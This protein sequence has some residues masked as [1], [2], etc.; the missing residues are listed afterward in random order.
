MVLGID[1]IKKG[2]RMV[3][4]PVEVRRNIRIPTRDDP[5]ITLSADLFIAITIDPVPAVI[6]VLP[7]RKDADA[8]IGC[9]AHYRWLAS[10]GYGCLLV[11]F[12]GTGSSDG[13][14]RPPFDPTEVDDAVAA[15]EWAAAQLWCSGKVGMWGM[16]YGAIMTLRTGTVRPAPLKAILPIEGLLDPERDFVHPAGSAGCMGS[17][18]L[19]GTETFLNQMLPPLHDY[20]THDEQRR[21]RH[22][23]Q[24]SEPWL[25]DLRRH[26]PGH[27]IWQ[28]RIIDPSKI[29]VPAFCVAGWRDIFCDASLRAYELIST[30]KKLLVGPWMH[31]LPDGSLFEAI[32]FRTLVLRW[33]DQWLKGIDTGLM[34]ELPVTLFVQGS[35]P[36]W[37]QLASWPPVARGRLFTTSGDTTLNPAVAGLPRNPKVTSVIA[38]WK[39]DPTVGAQSGLWGIPANGFGLPLDQH[40]DDVRCITSTTTAI[41]TDVVVVGRP[42]IRLRWDNASSPGRLVVRLTD[43][44]EN[45][46]SALISLGVLSAP[47]LAN[48]H[49][50]VLNPT[51]YRIQPGHR[52]RVSVGNAD[53]PRLWPAETSE[54]ELQETLGLSEVE[55]ELLEMGDGDG[56]TVSIPAPECSINASDA[57]ALHFQPLWTIARDPIADGVQVVVGQKLIALSPNREHLLELDYRSAARVSRQ[58][59]SAANAQST[60]VATVRMQTGETITVRVHTFLTRAGAQLSAQI[61]IDNNAIFNREWDV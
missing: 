31:S 5:G 16:S 37:R 15:I 17:L 38:D 24:I 13:D 42:V 27:P 4:Y 8:G 52:L 7:Y 55:L 25:L 59:P 19:W 20:G 35:R 22:R 32:E 50:V 36:G 46:R 40:E 14:Q 51:C 48:M 45:G 28:S 53:F 47:E 3:S 44:D 61:A 26:G 9:D 54:N 60:A 6:T 18:S 12:R 30:P 21:W 10:H 57:L 58:R 39:T 2:E 29:A 56:P 49:E 43:V 1:A 23:R 33:W 41:D 34:D 11:D